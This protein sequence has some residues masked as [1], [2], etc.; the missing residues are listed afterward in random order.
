[1]APDTSTIG[2]VS[3]LR[4]DEESAAA[5][6][7]FTPLTRAPLAPLALSEELPAAAA[8]LL[9]FVAAVAPTDFWFEGKARGAR[10]DFGDRGDGNEANM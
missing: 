10:E 8:A 6:A 2:R 9:F 7:G 4:E 3:A 1:M 5:A